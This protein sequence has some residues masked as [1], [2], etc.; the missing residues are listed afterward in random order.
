MARNKYPEI[1]NT[2]EG[3]NW[4]E[5]S[6]IEKVDKLRTEID[7]LLIIECNNYMIFNKKKSLVISLFLKIFPLK[8]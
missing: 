4:K 1:T 5:A 7:K 2:F 8:L 6:H 3:L